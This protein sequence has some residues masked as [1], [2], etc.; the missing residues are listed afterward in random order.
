M[1]DCHTADCMKDL[2]STLLDQSDLL[3]YLDLTKNSSF[4][5]WSGT[6]MSIFDDALSLKSQNIEE[7]LE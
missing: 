6:D 1:N 3:V 4:L 5:F 7:I 2:V